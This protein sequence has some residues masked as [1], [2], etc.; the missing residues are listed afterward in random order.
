MTSKIPS[1]RGRRKKNQTD[2]GSALS[3]E[4]IIFAALEYIDNHGLDKFSIRNLA[5]ALG[6]FPTAIY[7]YVAS[8]EQLLADVEA[9]VLSNLAPKLSDHS[10]QTYLR[11]VLVNCRKAIALHP[12]VAPLLG[13]QMSPNTGADLE[14]VEGIIRALQ[15]AGFSGTAL[16]GAY[17]SFLAALVGFTTQEFAPLPEN[18]GAWQEQ[19]QLRLKEVDKELYPLVSKHL[20][21]FCNRSFILRWLNGVDAPLDE[22]F[23]FYVDTIILGLEAMSSRQNPT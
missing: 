21:Q 4:M 16:M 18:A 20:P 10:W 17:N 19:M 5:T 9:L 3:K 11:S 14:L 22:G 12:N 23:D 15:D 7:W 1:P 13:A 2:D 8:R 6:V